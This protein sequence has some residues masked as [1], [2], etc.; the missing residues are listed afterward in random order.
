M[1]QQLRQDLLA[2]I[3]RGEFPP[4][5]LLPPENQLCERYGVSV[6]T[7][8]R[9]F[10]ELV[11]EG[12]VQRKAGVGSTVSSRVRQTRLPFL[13]ID[14]RGD[15]WRRTPNAMGG[16]VSGVGGSSWQRD[17]SFFMTGVERDEAVGYLRG[18][19]GDALLPQPLLRHARRPASQPGA[20][21]GP[22]AVHGGGHRARPV[23]SA[24]DPAGPARPRARF[25]RVRWPRRRRRA[26]S[27]RCK[28]PPPRG[29]LLL[30]R[31]ARRA[32]RP[33]AS[34]TL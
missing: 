11:K 31:T 21:A 30:R 25:S 27:R 16:I 19:V 5:S 3:R 32:S 2:R 20:S 1:Y 8:R 18:L 24:D 33:G 29:E 10:L 7:A 34:W 4:G 13:G 22:G 26:S 12:V 28:R 14:H 6:T 23:D 17:A 15:A 9:A